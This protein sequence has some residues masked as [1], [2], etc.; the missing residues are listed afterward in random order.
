MKINTHSPQET[1]Q[2]G[3]KTGKVIPSNHTISLNGS[4]GAGKTTLIKGIA[5]SIGLN[6]TNILSPYFNILFEYEIDSH[7]VLRHFDFMRL[8]NPSELHELNIE[9]ILQEEGLVIMEWGNRFPQ[10]IPED[11]LIIHIDDISPSDRVIEMECK[12]KEIIERIKEE[13]A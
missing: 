9:E 1:F 2:I 11:A 6:P 12:N 7:I 4:I 5:Y 8:K 10:I 13:F 3:Y